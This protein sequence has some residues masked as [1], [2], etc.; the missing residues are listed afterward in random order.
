MSLRGRT[1]GL[2]VQNFTLFFTSRSKR[3]KA[4]KHLENV[5]LVLSSC[6]GLD[7][8]PP[9]LSYSYV[10]ALTHTML[11]SG[12]EVCLSSLGLDEVRRLKPLRMLLKEEKPESALCLRCED[13]R[14]RQLSANQQEGLPRL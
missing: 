9:I 6:Y 12:G 5:K 7:I 8:F 1:L 14:G 3:K 10:E 2:L 4:L 11:T 13:P